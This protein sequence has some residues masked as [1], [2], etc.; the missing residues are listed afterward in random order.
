M[1]IFLR[2]LLLSIGGLN[3]VQYNY[4]WYWG[5]Y[6]LFYNPVL[7]VEAGNPIVLN[8]TS[9]ATV[10]NISSVLMYNNVL[11][12]TFLVTHRVLA[13]VFLT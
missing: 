5:N 1:I 10:D 2:V 13:W 7:V 6:S 4:S 8:L 3:V 11:Q 12:S 9:D